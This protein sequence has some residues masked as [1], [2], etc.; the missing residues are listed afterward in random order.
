MRADKEGGGVRC[1]IPSNFIKRELRSP[2]IVEFQQW[3]RIRKPMENPWSLWKPLETLLE[4]LSET[5]P[6]PFRKLPETV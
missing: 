5:L 3:K 2:D 4:T 1:Y 6:K